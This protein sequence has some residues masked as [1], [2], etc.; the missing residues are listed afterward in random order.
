LHAEHRAALAVARRFHG[1]AEQGSWSA[2]AIVGER[3]MAFALQL[4]GDAAGT[5]H[6]V[7]GC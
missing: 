6:H 5:R 4:L 1:T 2:E 3:M 7:D